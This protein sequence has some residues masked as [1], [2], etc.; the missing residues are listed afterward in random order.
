MLLCGTVTP[1]LL[2]VTLI[3]LLLPAP[4]S[5]QIVER[6]RGNWCPECLMFCT[7][8]NLPAC[9][10]WPGLANLRSESSPDWLE[11]SRLCYRPK[12]PT[13]GEFEVFASVTKT[14]DLASN[15]SFYPRSSCLEPGYTKSVHGGSP[16]SCVVDPFCECNV[17]YFVMLREQRLN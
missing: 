9:T 15:E 14:C 10:D 4:Q 11:I 6:T 5:C 8:D 3:V 1:S 2:L 16:P 12:L 13:N 17:E 7:L